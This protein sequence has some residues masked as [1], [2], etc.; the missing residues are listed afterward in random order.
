MQQKLP[1]LCTSADRRLRL[2]PP[3]P[4]KNTGKEGTCRNPGLLFMVY[5][6]AR[7]GA[8]ANRPHT[9]SGRGRNEVRDTCTELFDSIFLLLR[10]D[11]RMGH[12]KLQRNVD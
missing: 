12:C 7:Y 10:Q 9:Y 5:G 3:S 1:R 4:L 11:M 8:S 6:V 2:D